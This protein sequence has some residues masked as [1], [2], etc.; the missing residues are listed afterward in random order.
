MSLLAQS[1]DMGGQWFQL[2]RN[3]ESAVFVFAG[4]VAVA[5]ILAGLA[6]SYFAHRERMLKLEERIA[7]IEHGI[8]PDRRQAPKA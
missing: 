5:G 8:D 6:R 3:P 4:V 1:A 7:S 2:L